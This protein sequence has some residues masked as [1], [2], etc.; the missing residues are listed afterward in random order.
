MQN[1][2]VTHDKPR[3]TRLEA[4]IS[5]DQ[6]ELFQRAA[7]L[8]GRTLSELVIDSAREA[9]MKIVQEHEV[10]CLS[11]EEQVAFVNALLEPGPAGARL[12]EAVRG[13]RQKTG[14]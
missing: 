3:N 4:R 9:A 2:P 5:S 7:L 11:R 10:I 8:T 13:Y 6:K 12:S 14:L 1:T